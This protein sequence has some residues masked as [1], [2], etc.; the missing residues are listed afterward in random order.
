[1]ARFIIYFFIILN[2]KLF[3]CSSDFITKYD[4]ENFIVSDK[5]KNRIEMKCYEVNGNYDNSHV[6][7][8][9]LFE[10]APRFTK[11]LD[12]NKINKHFY[13]DKSE[14]NE[15]IVHICE[16][17]HSILNS[18]VDLFEKLNPCFDE[19]MIDD[20]KLSYRNSKKIMGFLCDDNAN[21]M[22]T[23]VNDDGI[24]CMQNNNMHIKKCIGD[25]IETHVSMATADRCDM[26]N[27]VRQCVVENLKNCEKLT[28]SN[29]MES[30]F[31]YMEKEMPCINGRMGGHDIKHYTTYSMDTGRHFN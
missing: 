22:T 18:F 7:E 5:V 17:H 30:L 8:N 28:A 2:V 27:V 3:L 12:I 11:A 19:T 21:K 4:I 20:I 1:M 6:V 16:N 24:E 25:K 29:F 26:I 23:L 31:A 9:A 14:L 13:M 10:F 15:F